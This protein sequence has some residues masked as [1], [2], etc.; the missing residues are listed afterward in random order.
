MNINDNLLLK[1][2]WNEFR[3]SYHKTLSKNLFQIALYICF[4]DLKL[5]LAK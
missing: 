5:C 1:I 3:N 4:L 2:S